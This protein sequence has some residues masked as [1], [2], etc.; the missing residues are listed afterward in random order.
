MISVIIP[1]YKSS[2]TLKRTLQSLELL[3]SALKSQLE[4]ILVFDGNDLLCNEIAIEWQSNTSVRNQVLHQEH[5]GVS[6]ARNNGVKI[7]RGNYI[8][9]LDADDEILLDRFEAVLNGANFNILIGKQELVFAD[10][11]YSNRPD[12]VSV[13]APSE[14]HIMSMVLNRKTFEEIG[15][16]SEDFTVGGDWEFVVRAR[17]AGFLIEYSDLYFLR[18]HIHSGNA[19]LDVHEVRKQ[20]LLSIRQHIRSRENGD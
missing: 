9:F 8:T 18:R 4:V 14:H 16:F 12:L 20:Q 6:S 15:G 11:R 17:K 10:D 5:A 13:I 3:D 7:A 19:S 2:S 1:I